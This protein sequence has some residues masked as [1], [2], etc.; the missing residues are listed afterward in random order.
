MPRRGEGAAY[1]WLLKHVDHQSKACLPWPFC[2]E[3]RSGRGLLGHNGGHHWAHRLMCEFAHGKPPTPKHEA[4]HECGKGHYGCVNPRHLKWKTT[5]QNQLDRRR[6]GSKLRNRY[7]NKSVLTPEQIA[8]IVGLRGKKP[9][10][11][12][13]K[14]FGVSL[15]C[16]QYWQH[17]RHR[18]QPPVSARVDAAL[19]GAPMNFTRLLGILY[20]KARPATV[21]CLHQMLQRYEYEV[22]DRVVYP[23]AQDNAFQ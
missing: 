20:P 5:S 3:A 15:G 7:G 17:E 2:R 16:V 23:R 9:Q 8:S 6:T 4:A 14:M 1:K 22:R 12:V 18:R 21:A 19:A 11:Q 10:T 13:A